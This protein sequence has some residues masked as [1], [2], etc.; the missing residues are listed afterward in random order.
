MNEG[1]TVTKRKILQE[2][3]TDS[4]SY[5]T[6]TSNKSEEELTKEGRVKQL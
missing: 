6:F 1:K 2:E 3:N 4:D 5:A